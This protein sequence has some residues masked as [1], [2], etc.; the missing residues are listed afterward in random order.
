MAA[1]ES[2]KYTHFSNIAIGTAS[3]GGGFE[4]AG[5][6]VTSTAAELNILDGVT[7]TAAEINAAADVSTRG[8]VVAATKVITAAESG[9]TFF[10]YKTLQ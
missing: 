5:T 8:E 9:K 4:L 10:L 7:A 6:A 3:G 1:N 2:T